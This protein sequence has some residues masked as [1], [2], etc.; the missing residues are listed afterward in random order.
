MSPASRPEAVSIVPGS[1]ELPPP[2]GPALTDPDTHLLLIVAP[3]AGDAVVRTAIRLAEAR[4]EGGDRTVLADAGFDDPRLH[5][6]LD[7]PNLEGLADVFDFGAS[8]GRV[9][10]RPDTRQFE[11]VPA[12]A[13]VLEPETILRSPRWSRIAAELAEESAVMLVF[14]HA[15]LPGLDALSRR[16][17]QAILVGDPRGVERSAEALSASCEVV[18]VVEPAESLTPARLAEQA[19]RPGELDATIFDHP[20]LTEPVVFRS[21][22]RRQTLAPYLWGLLLAVVVVLGGWL[23]YRQLTAAPP[24]ETVE[25][26]QVQ[27]EPQSDP[28]PQ[29]RPQPVE[30]AIGFSVAVEAHQDLDAARERLERLQRAE[31]DILFYL[32]PVSVNG[33]LFYRLLAGPTTDRESGMALMERLVEEGHKSGFDNWAVR[34]TTY[35]FYLG[36][37]TTREQA[38][39]RVARLAEAD[40]PTYV[41]PIRYE[42]GEPRYRVYGGAFESA[43]TAVVMEE[44]L[45]D[46]GIDA[47]LIERVGIPLEVGS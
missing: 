44:M 27:P 37:F 47:R 23:V 16:A 31:P 1:G 34:P 3:D 29:P 13:Y 22:R 19:G 18:A 43:A 35:A 5:E 36:E 20:E 17:G 38:E 11:F 33:S 46:A 9:M 2:L 14:A 45:D 25:Q 24:P 32:A 4:A 41:V 7:V 6:V 15:G 30:T 21:D 26:E 28:E 12:G 42:P 10:T 40:I 39:R 8:L